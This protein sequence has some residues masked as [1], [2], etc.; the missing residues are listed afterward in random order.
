MELSQAINERRSVRDYRSDPVPD[1]VL[2]QVLEAARMA[3]SWANSQITRFFAVK[4][5][6]VKLLIQGAVSKGNPA[7]NAL[8]QAPL[9]LVAAGIRGRSGFYKGSPSN[10]NGDYAMFDVALAVENAVLKARELGLGT[11]LMGVFNVDKIKE[12]LKLPAE[13]DP[14]ILTP[15]GYPTSNDQFTP[16]RKEISELLYWDRYEER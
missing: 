14:F 6:A 5:P 2:E 16:P 12:A 7:F 8:G 13:M 1:A 3:P 9:V 10:K 4:D 15:L 11:V